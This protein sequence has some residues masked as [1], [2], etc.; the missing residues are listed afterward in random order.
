MKTIVIPDVHGR[1]F[2]EDALNQTYDTMIFL[3]DYLDP[4]PKDK[5]SF[6]AAIVE[7]EWILDCARKDPKIILLLGNHD[8][9]Y[10]YNDYGCCRFNSK[11]YTVC[12]KLFNDNQDLFLNGCIIDNAFFSHAGISKEWLKYNKLDKLS[13][14]EIE[15]VIYGNDQHHILNQIG[16]TRSGV[17]PCGGPFWCDISEFKN[18]YEI[19]Q[20]F[21]H[22]QLKETGKILKIENSY[23]CDSRDWFIWDGKELKNK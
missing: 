9:H 18:P 6:E 20:I 7:F 11:Y 3:G 2:W 12:H 14:D 4:Y 21:G 1:R 22:S 13:P 23:L 10:L 17:Y 15:A 8:I 19:P 16:Y 5:I